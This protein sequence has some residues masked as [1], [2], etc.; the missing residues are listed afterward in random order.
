MSRQKNRWSFILGFGALA[1]LLLAG[2]PYFF[3]AAHGQGEQIGPV[4]SYATVPSAS[5]NLTGQGQRG[6]RQGGPAQEPPPEPLHFQ[7]MGP[8]SAGRIAAVAGVPGD[9]TTYYAG[10]ASGG[11]WKS[12]DSGKTFV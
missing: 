11:I 9:T 3:D 6:G 4:Q 8:P 12:T 5:S 2:V 1:F 10:A 7:Y